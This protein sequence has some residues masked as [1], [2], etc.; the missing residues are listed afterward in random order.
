MGVSSLR[1]E[2][3]DHGQVTLVKPTGYLP[4]TGHGALDECLDV[5]CAQGHH[6]LIVD[7]GAVQD[8]SS[9]VLGVF[10][11]YK[12]KLEDHGGCLILVPGE[13]AMTRAINASGL[14]DALDVRPTR[15][16]AMKL[17]KEKV[18]SGKWEALTV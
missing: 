8:L 2:V 6:L 3:R 15:D 16:E 17:A 13:E 4:S 14:R 11:F 7:L 18:G 12:K 10:L 5:L 1:I 9:T